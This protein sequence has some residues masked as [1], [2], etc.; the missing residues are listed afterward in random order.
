MSDRSRHLVSPALRYFA[1]VARFGSF[2]AA[3]RELNV[4]SSAVNRQIL[5]LEA[6]L[7]V[8]LFERIG[9][10]IRLS[11]SGEVLLRHVTDAIRDFEDAAA[12]ID[13]L[14]GL[15]RGRVA[16]ATVESV[17][18]DVLPEIVRLFLQSHPG[19]DVIVTVAGS[20]EATR[21]VA[22]GD[23]DLAF[24]FNPEEGRRLDVVLRRVLMIGAVVTPDHPLASFAT[25]RLTDCLRFP[26]A[27]PARGL[28][29][30]AALEA[31]S[32]FRSSGPR[33]AVESST[34]SFMRAVAR[35]GRHV[36]FQTLM[37]LGPDLE[38]GKLV[39]KPLVDADLLLDKFALVVRSDRTLKLAAATFHSFAMQELARRMPVDDAETATA[40]S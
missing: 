15:K 31:T 29:I 30:R 35:G 5:G 18:Q 36:A 6:D 21:L 38:S 14:K 16:I 11:P 23:A 20:D 19:I 25:V 8:A 37:D 40:R 17:A 3:A 10:S 1:A 2:R 12:E 32:A 7:G 39:F 22:E 24:T 9:R 34:L 28:S 13:A 26:L 33:V 4:A 27:L